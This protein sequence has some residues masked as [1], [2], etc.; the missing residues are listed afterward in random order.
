VAV[1]VQDHQPVSVLLTAY[2]ASPTRLKR[3]ANVYANVCE[4]NHEQALA[5]TQLH[6]HKG[7]LTVY[8]K[9]PFSRMFE[10][11]LRHAWAFIGCEDHAAVTIEVAR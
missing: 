11:H 10:S 1:N 7:F 9:R 4:W 8:T 3:L 6:D 5:I 2:E